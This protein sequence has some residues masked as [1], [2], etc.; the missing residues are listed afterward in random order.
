VSAGRRGDP[1]GP[2]GHK[3]YRSLDRDADQGGGDADG[4]GQ[5]EAHGH[6]VESGFESEDGI[7]HHT[8]P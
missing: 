1:L 3:R 6:A 2:V 7:G 8:H 5:E 4:G